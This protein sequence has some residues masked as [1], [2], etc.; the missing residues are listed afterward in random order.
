MTGTQF[1]LPAYSTV[2]IRR[3]NDMNCLFL[4]LLLCCCGQSNGCGMNRGGCRNGSQ[5]NERGS[6]ERNVR[7]ACDCMADSRVRRDRDDT[8]RDRDDNRRDRDDNRREREENRRDRDDNRRDRD[9]PRPFPPFPER[10]R[11]CGC[12]D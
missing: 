8:R 9:M 3:R 7:D 4:L 1:P 10:D 5:R 11:D 12:D 6:E 2:N